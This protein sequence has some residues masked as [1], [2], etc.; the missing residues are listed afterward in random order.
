MRGHELENCRTWV[1][2]GD[3]LG[4]II[5]VHGGAG[6]QGAGSACAGEV[7]EV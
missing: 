7:E 2:W 1:V 3:C 4:G 5:R 6:L